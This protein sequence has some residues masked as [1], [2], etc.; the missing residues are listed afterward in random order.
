MNQ[1][2]T[3]K[4]QQKFLNEVET[5]QE[6]VKSLTLKGNYSVTEMHNI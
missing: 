5:G 4:I 3:S 2:N 1:F 6:A